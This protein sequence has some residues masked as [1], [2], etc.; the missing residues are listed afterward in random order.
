MI[1]FLAIILPPDLAQVGSIDFAR[2]TEV[3]ARK[4]NGRQV[5]CLISIESPE[6]TFE[7]FRWFDARSANDT[8]R[9]VR[10]AGEGIAREGE[11]IVVEGRFLRLY[12]AAKTGEDGTIFTAILE[13]RLIGCGRE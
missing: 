3:E 12:H 11:T 6:W 10:F 13:Y 2:I 5:R 7:G 4:M 9:T 8:I 1:L